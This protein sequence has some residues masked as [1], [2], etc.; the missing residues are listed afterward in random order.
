MLKVPL[1]V[2]WLQTSI[3]ITSNVVQLI[4]VRGISSIADTQY[5]PS[6]MLQMNGWISQLHNCSVQ[7]RQGFSMSFMFECIS[8]I[9][10]KCLHWLWWLLHMIML[11]TS[12]TLKCFPTALIDNWCFIEC[13]SRSN[14]LL[15]MH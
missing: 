14:R 12:K 2:L 3:I 15:E 6:H 13:G 11:C 10:A 4:F 7:S 1:S 9:N 8:G 5:N